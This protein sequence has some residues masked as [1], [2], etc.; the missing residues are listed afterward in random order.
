MKLLQLLEQDCTLTP[1]QLARIIELAAKGEVGVYP[2]Q[3]DEPEFCD[4]EEE[5]N[6]E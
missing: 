2:A 3:A 4:E 1:E 5:T 6:E